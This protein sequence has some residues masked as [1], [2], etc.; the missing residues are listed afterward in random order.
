MEEVGYVEDGSPWAT[1]PP[2]PGCAVLR[3][4]IFC[5]RRAAGP[6]R[7]QYDEGSLLASLTRR[8]V[9]VPAPGR[10]RIFIHGRNQR[11]YRRHFLHGQPGAR[12][13][14]DIDLYVDQDGS[15]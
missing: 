8:A 13:V 7:V 4:R 12:Q 3:D 2:R 10:I 5:D 9:A 14:F 11:E 6:G 15:G 1:C